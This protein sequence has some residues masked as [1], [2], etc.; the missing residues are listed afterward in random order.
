MAN[1]KSQKKRIL[2]NEK[3]RVLNI[4][5]K[6]KVRTAIKKVEKAAEAKDK[7]LATTNLTLAISLIDKSVVKHIQHAKTA[8][9][10]KSFIQNLV[11]NIK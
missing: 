4:A 1:I 2:T 10:Q 5:F 8:A 3:S 11:N 6:S 9:R 7:A